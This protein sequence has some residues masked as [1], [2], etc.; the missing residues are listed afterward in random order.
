MRNQNS[1]KS[2]S[3]NEDKDWGNL[4]NG[5]F[6]WFLWTFPVK[7]WRYLNLWEWLQ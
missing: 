2:K 3:K 4:P 1:P 6:G 5:M 7:I